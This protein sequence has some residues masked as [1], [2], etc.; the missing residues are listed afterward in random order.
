[1]RDRVED[2]VVLVVA[3]EPEGRPAH[4]LVFADVLGPAQGRAAGQ[5][6]LLAADHARK[7]PAGDRRI[8]IAVVHLV[9]RGEA[10]RELLRRDRRGGAEAAGLQRVVR[11]VVAGEREAAARD[12][13]VLAGRLRLELR[14]AADQADLVVLHGAVQRGTGDRGVGVAVVDLV[15]GGEAAGE[16]LR[17]DR[18][19]RVGIGVLQGV[20]IVVVAAPPAAAAAHLPLLAGRRRLHLR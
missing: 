11:L 16:L 18:R 8:A 20:V 3:A 10:A 5:R 7:R 12:R 15:G 9:A 6:D 1:V 13:P 4:S 17:R 2:V 19:G 14:R